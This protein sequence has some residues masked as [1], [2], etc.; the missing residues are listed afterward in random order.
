M[1]ANSSAYI[2]GLAKYSLLINVDLLM[3]LLELLK[4]LVHPDHRPPLSLEARLLSINTALACL[5]V[6]YYLFTIL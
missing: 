3:D 4:R 2:Q 6:N 5:Q 1:K